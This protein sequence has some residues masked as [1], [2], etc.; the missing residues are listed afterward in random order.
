MSET[1]PKSVYV[2]V[3]IFES[4]SK[5]DIDTCNL[6]DIVAAREGIKVFRSEYE[7]IKPPAWETIKTEMEHSRALFLLVGPELVKQQELGEKDWKYTQNWIAYEVGLACALGID[8]WVLCNNVNINFPVPYLNNYSIGGI[9]TN[10]DGFERWIL[11]QYVE[12]MT[13]PFGFNE[14]RR[15]FCPYE[16]CGSKFNFHNVIV[17]DGITTCPTCLNPL[18][19]QNGWLL[20]EAASSNPVQK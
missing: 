17:K 2:P 11:R 7:A 3:Q 9:E 10:A 4:H 6:F 1:R 15:L 5:L 13:F 12:G 14:K 18:V 16:D 20:E 19:F 8:V